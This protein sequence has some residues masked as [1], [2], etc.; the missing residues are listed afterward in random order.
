MKMFT[1][2]CNL[3]VGLSLSLEIILSSLENYQKQQILF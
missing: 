2:N 1:K 3:P